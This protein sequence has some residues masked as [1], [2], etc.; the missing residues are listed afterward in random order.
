MEKLGVKVQLL[1]PFLVVKETLERIGV[2]SSEKKIITPSCYIIHKNGE[3]FITHFKQLLA[4]DGF[5]KEISKSDIN[6]QNAIITLLRN[7]KM[8][9]ILEYN[10]YQQELKEKIYVLPHKLKKETTINHKY[11]IKNI[12]KDWN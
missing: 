11:R 6:R 5:K 9:K 1:V 3:Y 4:N 7:W 12:K 2:Y 10:V 8:I